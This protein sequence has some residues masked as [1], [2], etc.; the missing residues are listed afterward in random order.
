MEKI[1]GKN[2][3]PEKAAVWEK[4]AAE[5]EKHGKELLEGEFEKTAEDLKMIEKINSYLAE[6][7]EEAGAEGEMEPILPEQ[8]HYLS[9]KSYNKNFSEEA[10]AGSEALYSSA[11]KAAYIN[12]EAY[13]ARLKKHY[14]TL[15]EATHAASPHQLLIKA[16]EA[17]IIARKC[18][19]GTIYLHYLEEDKKYELFGGFN[20]AVTEKIARET[21][22]K[23]KGEI[24]KEFNI[25]EEET[26][27]FEV[28]AYEE[29]L[30]ILDFVI[31]K[32]ARKNGETEE[33]VWNKIKKGYFEGK[34][35][36][37]R[38]IERACGAGALKI[39]AALNPETLTEFET[40][41]KILRYFETNDKSEEEKLAKE[42]LKT[43]EFG[44]FQEQ[45]KKIKK[46][47]ILF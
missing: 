23:H 14:A 31:L 32:T 21:L 45:R 1:I 4:T 5:T 9:Q 25:S 24:A 29:Y 46:S 37:L 13:P 6:E 11:M 36:H 8:I 26:E 35:A 44:R 28:T 33:A 30:G 38:D 20:E 17:K 3:T 42:I 7:F 16:E 10:M 22:N 39:L 41:E 34:M 15:H 2:L 18:G 43:G 12:A 40:F 47:R 19:Y 27:S